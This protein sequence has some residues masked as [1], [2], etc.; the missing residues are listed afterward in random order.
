MTSS[1]GTITGIAHVLHVITG[2]GDGGA[3]AVLHRVVCADTSFRHSVISLSDDGKYGTLLRKAGI[4]VA[5]LQMDSSVPSLIKLAQLVCMIRKAR[6]NVVQTWM[7]HADLMGGL[8]ARL[9]GNN[10]VVWGNHN[11]IVSRDSTKLATR[12]IVKLNAYLSHWIPRK[13]VSCS[14]KGAAVHAELGYA[15]DRAVVVNNGYDL[16][17]FRPDATNGSRVRKEFSVPSDS[18]FFG[19]VA[20]DDPFKDHSTLLAGFAMVAQALPEAWLVLVG[21]GM[22]P[23]NEHITAQLKQDRIDH[24][25]ILA[26]RRNDVPAIMNAIDVHVLSSTAEAFPNVLSEA[27]ACGT[28]CAVTNVGDCAIIV[29]ETGEV[30]EPQNPNALSRAMLD[31]FGRAREEP[32]LSRAC[33]ARVTD[34]FSLNKMIAGYT[35]VWSSARAAMP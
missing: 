9:A 16:S 8:A 31:I 21:S 6:P 3:E 17:V 33:R 27:M 10:A 2:L 30:C 35:D 1:S 29:G 14:E 24:R 26:G 34:H 18:P 22:T 20:R 19:C 4:D 23:E 12:L 28:P 11:S 15:T 7:Y 32:N 13:I 5:V 25:V